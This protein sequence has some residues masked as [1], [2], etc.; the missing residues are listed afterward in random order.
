[1]KMTRI[2]LN[3]AIA[4]LRELEPPPID[5]ANY[6]PFSDSYDDKY[7]EWRLCYGEY[8][9]IP[10]GWWPRHNYLE[11]GAPAM[12][13]LEEM[14]GIIPI[15]EKEGCDP[16]LNLRGIDKGWRVIFSPDMN[17]EN[18]VCVVDQESLFDVI[19][20]IWYL[21]KTGIMVEL[22]DEKEVG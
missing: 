5:W 6:D 13:L 2:E 12:W 16:Y 8:S 18:N 15:Q 11:Y 3:R 20:L 17:A 19:S 14:Q 9:H 4:G 1:M 7:K 21:W 22:V 10:D